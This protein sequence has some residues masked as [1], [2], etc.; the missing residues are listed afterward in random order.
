MC[1]V[2]FIPQADGFLLGMNRDESRERPAALPPRIFQHGKRA[3]LHPSEKTGG[4]WIGVNNAGLC[5]A[6]LNWYSIPTAV[7][8]T[9]TSRGLVIPALLESSTL[10]EAR[11]ALKNFKLSGLAPFRLVVLSAS[12]RRM[13]EFRWNQISLVEMRHTWKSRHWFSSGFDE[14]GAQRE[15]SRTARRAAREHDAGKL[16]WLRRLHSSHAPVSGPFSI[17]MH[18]PD[19]ATVSYTEI[20]VTALDT[21]MHYHDG[22]LCCACQLAEAD[23][24]FH[25]RL[26]HFY[27]FRNQRIAQA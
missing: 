26:T 2:T 14:P 7:T 9:R 24:P 15:R 19:A 16:P 11:A 4:T 10:A 3:A 5:C 17:C 22:P 21:T 18:R 13:R 27:A 23:I 6:L 1:S 8:R 12:E 25:V 20:V